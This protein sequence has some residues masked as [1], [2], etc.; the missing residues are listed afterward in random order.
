MCPQCPSLCS[1]AP[2]ASLCLIPS[3]PPCP[4]ILQHPNLSSASLHLTLL[5]LMWAGGQG[6][7]TPSMAQKSSSSERMI[8]SR[9]FP[10]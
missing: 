2:R 8:K 5:S 10:S 3:P 1:S 4:L 9:F 6:A 7:G